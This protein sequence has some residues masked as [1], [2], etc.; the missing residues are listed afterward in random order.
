MEERGWPVTAS[1]GSV[2]FEKAPQT[3]AE[4]VKASD[5]AMYHAKNNGKNQIYMVTHELE[6]P[7]VVESA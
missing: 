6:L 1:F 5:S 7:D 3:V 2:T 4:M